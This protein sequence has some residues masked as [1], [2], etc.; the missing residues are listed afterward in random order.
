MRR[1]F[2]FVAYLQLGI[3]LLLIF[4]I[5]F[6]FDLSTF[7]MVLKSERILFSIKLSVVVATIATMFSTVIAVPTAYALSRHK[8]FF[9]GIIDALLELPLIISPAALGALILIFFNTPMGELLQKK[10][11]DIIFTV[12]GIILAQ[13]IAT[14]GVATRLI[15]SV[16]DEIPV[17]YEDVAKTLGATPLKAFTSIVVPLSKRG[18]AAS[19]L[20]VWAKAFGEFGATITVG[21]TMMMKTETLPIAIFMSLASAE[22]VNASV[23]IFIALLIGLTVIFF[24]KLL[25]KYGDKYVDS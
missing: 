5:F 14:A 17:R 23:L 20:L 10:G 25:V 11:V 12:N 4:S 3:Y 1:T 7:I 21:G 13:F 9:S 15:K 6:F 22:I 19:S 2:L 8:F 16:M 18:I 24:V